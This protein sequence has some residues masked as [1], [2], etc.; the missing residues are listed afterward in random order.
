MAPSPNSG[1]KVAAER[2]GWSKSRTSRYLIPSPSGLTARAR[3]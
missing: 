3:S 2:L 1:E